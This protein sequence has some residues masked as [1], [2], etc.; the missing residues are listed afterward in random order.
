MRLPVHTLLLS[1][2]L[3]TLPTAFAGPAAPLE[4]QL[5]QP[6]GYEFTAIPRGDEYASWTETA[7]GHSIVQAN[8]RWYYA[9]P[10]GAG[11][12]QASPWAVGSLDAAALE[13]L[14][15]HLA[16]APDE[17]YR[18]PRYPRR[19]APAN[20]ARSA[21]IE[22][23]Q[24]PHSQPVL[25]ILVDYSDETFTYS[26]ASFRNLMYSAVPGVRDFYLENSYDQFSIEPATESFDTAND[27]VVHVTRA[28]TH[29][30]QGQN[31]SVSRAEA[32][33][34]ITLADPYVD[35]ASYDSDGSGMLTP[36]ELSIVIILAGYET[37]YGGANAPT[38]NVWGHVAGSSVFGLDVNVDGKDVQYYAMFGETHAT[39]L[40]L[41]G[42]HQATIGVM[43]HEL[44]HLML[45]LPDLYDS[46][47]SSVG[48]G[49]WGLMGGGSWNFTGSYSGDSPAHFSAWSKTA[50][51]FTTPL[52]IDTEQ[53][54]VSLPSVHASAS[55]PRIW[56]DPYRAHEYFLVENRQLAGYDAGLPGDG[57]LIWHIDERQLFNSDETHKR[58][59]LEEADG[60]DELDSSPSDSGDT[61]DPWPG[62]TDA[63]NF[64]DTTV[65]DSKDYNGAATQI[66]VKDISASMATM[67]ADIT[68]RAGSLFDNVRYDEAGPTTVAGL[69]S[70]TIWIGL[71]VTNSSAF[72]L[73][74][75][76][77]LFVTDQ[78][79]ATLDIYY[80]ES[81]TG[82]TPQNLIY[83][84][85]GIAGLPGWNRI[86]FATPQTFPLGAERGIVV[87]IVNDSRTSPASLDSLGPNSG[88]S[89]RDGDG[90]GTFLGLPYDLNLIALLGAE[91][92]T[93]PTATSI[94]PSTT[95]PTNADTVSFDVT[96]SENVVNFNDAAD[97]TIVH[98][99]TAHSG[100]NITG[101]GA[102]YSVEVSGISGDGNFT[103][104]VN[105][106]SDVQDSGAN[107]LAGSVTSDPVV[108]DN[109]APTVSIG[110]P[111]AGSTVAGPV[112]Y[113][114]TYT[115]A[116]SVTLVAGDVTLNTT[117]TATGSVDV[118]GAGLGSRTVTI[119]SITGQGT[120]G[121][122]VAAD[123]ASDT[124][125]NSAAG[126]GPSTT[127]T[128]TGMVSE[129]IFD[130]S[131]E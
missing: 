119:S 23:V 56:V 34:I 120:L 30:N 81:L 39:T 113:T 80:Y 116:D 36:D 128:V 103:L 126:A 107:P 41:P 105:T 67:M 104:Q 114:I 95:G 110:A 78:V 111:S 109:T 108:I 122:S 49:R 13:A 72:S 96:F 121:I 98:S 101:S 22:A 61:G 127:F 84:E 19:I 15:R 68:P 117:D 44:G 4:L 52:D 100:V 118:S 89:Y 115:G 62:S 112:S 70:T 21:Q 129:K 92:D 69:G 63:T 45:N 24:L 130:D 71:R 124:A 85:T 3:L 1:L 10:D 99:G 79:S 55:A 90:V 26:D 59:D 54:G 40:N 123:T 97:L 14:P 74:H 6:N 37:S 17:R 87:K 46:D 94:V 25:T 2:A 48:I 28:T 43:C 60:L 7:D 20:N 35:F 53:M 47:G 16:P 75:G 5:R 8:G 91:E 33:E 66:E 83:S 88:R 102:A 18:E 77:D 57:L 50:T 42:A 64:D 131:F 76:I 82:G 125:G 32:V 12:L 29:P 86:M 93:P 65:P 31:L 38:P 51:G 27:G 11:G 73:L 9:E 106:A 58:V